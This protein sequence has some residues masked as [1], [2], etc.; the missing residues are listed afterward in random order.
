MAKFKPHALEKN[1]KAPVAEQWVI[2]LKEKY[3]VS[4]TFREQ[5]TCYSMYGVSRY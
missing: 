5:Y 4:R 3:C 1:Y 2:R